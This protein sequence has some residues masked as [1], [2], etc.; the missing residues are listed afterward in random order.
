MEM[1]VF[2]YDEGTGKIWE[3]AA[4]KRIRVCSE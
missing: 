2:N 1:G 3:E 4:L